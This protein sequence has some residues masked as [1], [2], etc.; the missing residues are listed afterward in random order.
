VVDPQANTVSV[1]QGHGETAI[2]RAGDTL[3]GGEVIPGFRV[4]VAKIFAT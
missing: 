2:L 4:A 1:Y 3:T